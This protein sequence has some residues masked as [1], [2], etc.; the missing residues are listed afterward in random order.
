MSNALK[1]KAHEIETA[2][3]TVDAHMENSVSKRARLANPRSNSP[4]RVALVKLATNCASRGATEVPRSTGTPMG[5][6]EPCRWQDVV[7]ENDAS[8]T[9]AAFCGRVY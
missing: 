6:S 9:L 4:P 5:K 1:R 7:L 3:G 2:P 8:G